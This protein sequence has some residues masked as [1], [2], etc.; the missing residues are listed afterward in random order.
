MFDDIEIHK[1]W[2]PHGYPSGGWQT[3][4]L[5]CAL[6]RY[7]V[8]QAGRL[9]QPM[10]RYEDVPLEERPNQRFPSFGAIRAIQIGE[11]DANYH[12]YIN[13]YGYVD[14]YW[15]DLRLKFT[16]GQLVDVQAVHADE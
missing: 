2:L 1:D 8:N 13:A 16:D 4:D 11:R 6:T 9:I 7:S 15:V 3:K 14:S 5:E 12:G 10:Y